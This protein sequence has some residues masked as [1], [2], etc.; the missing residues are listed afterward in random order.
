LRQGS[1]NVQQVC[2]TGGQS[3]TVYRPGGLWQSKVHCS[4]VL[5]V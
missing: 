5:D 4:L 3:I 2:L 1:C